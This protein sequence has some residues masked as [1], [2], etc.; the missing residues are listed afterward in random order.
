MTEVICARCGRTRAAVAQLPYSGDLGAEIR[1]KV[2]QSCWNEWLETEV[3]VI[4]ELRLD[5]M[6]PRSQDILV[7]HMRE[8]LMLD[9]Q[10][11]EA[12]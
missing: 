12:P 3:I 10:P 1:H 8:F 6:N 2:C 11:P 4:N 7:Q 9:G 5:F